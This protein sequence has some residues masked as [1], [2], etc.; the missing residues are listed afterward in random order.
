MKLYFNGKKKEY[1]GEGLWGF[2]LDDDK[3]K[4]YVLYCMFD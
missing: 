1:T 4:I 2:S 3:I